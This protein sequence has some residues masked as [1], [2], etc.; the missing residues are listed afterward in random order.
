Q[1]MLSQYRM[2]SV[3]HARQQDHKFIATQ[4]YQGVYGAHD[5][6][7]TPGHLDEYLV[8]NGMA[9][10]VVERFEVVLGDEKY[11]QYAAIIACRSRLA[12]QALFQIGT[13]AKAGQRIMRRV[14]GMAL[15]ICRVLSDIVEH[16]D[17]V[18]HIPLGVRARRDI[19]C[20]PED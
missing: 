17:K 8:T 20:I 15:F 4:P 9:E 13:V 6:A 18:G 19:Q 16:A 5:T 11:C 14:M 10:A 2:L 3:N 1:Q 12:C 7:Q